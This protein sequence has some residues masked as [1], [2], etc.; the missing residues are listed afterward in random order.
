MLLPSI[1][2]IS[3]SW[4]ILVVPGHITEP[5][6][7]RLIRPALILVVLNAFNSTGK[8]EKN[9]RNQKQCRFLLTAS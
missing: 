4:S 6:S 3:A 9:E 7:M 8:L 5:E 2:V 1:T